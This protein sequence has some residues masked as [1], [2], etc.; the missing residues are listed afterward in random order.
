MRQEIRSLGQT[1]I[2]QYLN[3]NDSITKAMLE[4][5][6]TGKKIPI[7]EFG[8]S[9]DRITRYSYPLKN[10]ILDAEFDGKIKI[11]YNE[12]AHRVPP[13]LA[14]YSIKTG[15][16]GFTTIADITQ[17]AS[18]DK[19][20]KK[21][22]TDK[23]LYSI[24]TQAYINDYYSRS[25][26]NTIRVMGT[27]APKLAEC[28]G[29]LM[30]K[31]FNRLFG[32]STNSL[33]MDTVLYCI[34]KFYFLNVLGYEYSTEEM[35]TKCINLTETNNRKMVRDIDNY[36]S[37]ENYRSLKS[38]IEA[39]ATHIPV[40]KKL[41][42]SGFIGS[43]TALYGTGSIFAIEFFPTLLTLV[44]FVVEGSYLTINTA[45]VEKV[46]DKSAGA[47]YNYIVNMMKGN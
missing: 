22:L 6:V 9:F 43:F 5:F 24:L 39:L 46:I 32:L 41:T 15:N 36:I 17:F 10:K 47:A 37:D 33:H 3:N 14:A 27:N 20:G 45:S 7:K 21:K 44:I 26:M 23:N 18:V 35:N 30:I 38:F 12:G 28:Y 40:C 16:T 8:D 34:Y 1:E 11:A 31:V 42:L 2:Y 19:D 4:T 25:N 29:Q 13:F